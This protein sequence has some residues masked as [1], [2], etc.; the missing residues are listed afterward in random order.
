M[1]DLL[2]L[3]TTDERVGL[4]QIRVHT[5]LLADVELLVMAIRVLHAKLRDLADGENFGGV[6]ARSRPA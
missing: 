3:P 2:A 5:T 1:P 4:G 6:V